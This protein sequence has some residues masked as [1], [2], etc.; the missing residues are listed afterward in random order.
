MQF[1]EVLEVWSILLWPN[2]TSEITPT[3]AMTYL[4]GYDYENMK[5]EPTFF[6]YHVDDV[7]VGINSGHK[8]IN[9][10]YRSRG[11][12]VFPEYRGRGIGVELLTATINQAKLEGCNMCWSYPKHSSWSTYQ[13]AGFMLSSDWEKS[14][15][16]DRNAYCVIEF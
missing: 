13:K 15:T 5:D 2:R 8:T 10:T 7:L 11:L 14:E 16:S 9:N 4:G 1:N 6:G 12:Y 3:S